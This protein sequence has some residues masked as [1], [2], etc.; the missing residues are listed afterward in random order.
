MESF[1]SFQYISGKSWRLRLKFFFPFCHH[2]EEISMQIVDVLFYYSRPIIRLSERIGGTALVGYENSPMRQG[3]A[4]AWILYNKPRLIPLL[5]RMV[6]RGFFQLIGTCPPWQG[7]WKKSWRQWSEIT[8]TWAHPPRIQWCGKMPTWRKKMCHGLHC[9][10]Q[11]ENQ[12]LLRADDTSASKK[13][14]VEKMV[15]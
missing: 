1:E 10:R 13:K 6:Y 5:Y 2:R 14:N 11:V 7:Q 12:H 4:L 9:S 8:R 15:H 3:A